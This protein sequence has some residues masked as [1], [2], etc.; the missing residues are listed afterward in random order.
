MPPWSRPTATGASGSA[1]S[2]PTTIAD[3]GPA[4]T[5]EGA[6]GMA[7]SLPPPQPSACEHMAPQARTST[8]RRSSPPSLLSMESRIGRQYITGRGAVLD[9]EQL[10]LDYAAGDLRA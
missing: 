9:D 10:M 5:S 3:A 7:L 1:R 8:L 2:V 4:A 6:E